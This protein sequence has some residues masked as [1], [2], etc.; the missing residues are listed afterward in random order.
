MG[1]KIEI[2]YEDA[3]IVAVNKPAGVLFDW[4]LVEHQD[5]IPAH[6]LDKETSGVILFAK[7]QRAHDFLKEQFQKRA[8][9]KKYLALV[10][11]RIKQE[12]GLIDTPIGRSRSDARKRL[13]GRMADGKL[14]EALTE[15]RVVKRFTTP[16]Q[17]APLLDKEGM[18]GGNFFTLLEI[19]PRTG[20]THQIR[21]HLKS[22]GH[23]IVGD[24]LYAPRRPFLV[25]SALDSIYVDRLALHAAAIKFENLAGREIKVEAPL[26]PN[27]EKAFNIA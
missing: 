14:R 26:P 12:C 21:V 10:W 5:F 19:F 20:R 2:L 6:R 17:G 11:G 9:K 23:P 18:G 8:V 3:D 24:K 16:P 15:Y 22:I 1:P 4:V 25:N 7:N 27:L 13:A